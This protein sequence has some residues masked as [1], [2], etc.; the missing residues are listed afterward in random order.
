[1]QTKVSQH[2]DQIVPIAGIAIVMSRA[3]VMAAIL[4]WAPMSYGVA[5]EN[6]APDR[7]A[8]PAQGTT[9]SATQPTCAGLGAVGSTRQFELTAASAADVGCGVRH[10]VAAG[11][12]AGRQS[13]AQAA[14]TILLAWHAQA[15]GVGR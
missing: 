15:R 9:D 13:Q 6:I 14:D 5:G 11:T 2:Y 8:Q 10:D 7:V 1:M 4:T 12:S 3:A